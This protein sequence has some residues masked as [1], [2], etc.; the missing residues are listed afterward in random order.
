M[1]EVCD[2]DLLRFLFFFQLF[3]T[4]ELMLLKKVV[5]MRR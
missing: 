2:A 1:T 4:T 3:L 5:V